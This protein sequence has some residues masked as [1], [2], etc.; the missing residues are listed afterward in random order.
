MRTL[1][2]IFIIIASIAISF[3]AAHA[4][5]SKTTNAEIKT[6]LL[7]NIVKESN[8]DVILKVNVNPTKEVIEKTRDIP[9]S[10]L[11]MLLY[12]DPKMDLARYNKVMQKDAGTNKVRSVSDIL[13]A[14]DKY[15]SANNMQLKQIKFSAN[16]AR[17]KL[18]QGLPLF[19]SLY[20]SGDYGKIADREKSRLAATDI[21]AWKKS[22]GKLQLKSFNLNKNLI[23]FALMQ[24]YN[25]QTGEFLILFNGKKHWFT[26]SELKKVISNC[27]ELRI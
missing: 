17:L 18:D 16:N 5:R 6:K 25:K 10:L 13:E 7:Q 9:T 3:S 15:L 21:A 20:S 26:E 1:R 12:V 14:T 2:N 27:H 23:T 11:V 4:Q 22:L 19:I 8:G 24:G